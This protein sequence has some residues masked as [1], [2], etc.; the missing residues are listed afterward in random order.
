MAILMIIIS[1]IKII[2]SR[3]KEEELTKQRTKI[4]WSIL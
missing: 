3:G 1:G 2:I 4:T